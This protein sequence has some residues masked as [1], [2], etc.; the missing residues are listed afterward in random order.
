MAMSRPTNVTVD[1]RTAV[2]VLGAAGAAAFVGWQVG[3]PAL[4]RS[5]T[6]TA[7]AAGPSCVAKPEM[8]EGPFFVDDRLNRSDIR[9]DPA[10]GAVKTGV[11]LRVAFKVSRADAACT[12]LAGALVDVWHTDALGNYS[13]VGGESGKKYL[14]GYQATDANG[15]AQFTT[16]FPG[17]YPGRTPHIHF[18]I[19]VL[20]GEREAYDFTSQLFFD[21][22]LTRRVYATGPYAERGAA[23]RTNAR[24]GIFRGGS[25]LLLALA[26]DGEGYAATFDIGLVG[27]PKQV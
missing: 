21:D 17:W 19:R 18:K 20:S 9:S 13:D 5:G 15:V 8:T 6:G 16:I 25:D 24:D 22:A 3:W 7:G 10:T 2:R 4:F 14:R 11:P 23:D 1:R 26:P 12:P 27:V